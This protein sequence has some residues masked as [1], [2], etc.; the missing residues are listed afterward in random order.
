MMGVHS[1]TTYSLY[2][3]LRH[4]GKN[5]RATITKLLYYSFVEKYDLNDN[6]LAVVNYNNPLWDIDISKLSL[7]CIYDVLKGKSR[8]QQQIENNE[9][10][11]KIE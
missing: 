3:I 9:N 11:V 4:K 6:T 5:K 1:S 10:P 2:C 7:C 8:S